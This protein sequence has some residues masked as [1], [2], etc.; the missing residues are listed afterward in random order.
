[1]AL[2]CTPA[3]T[4]HLI[5]WYPT[6][7]CFTWKGLL[8]HNVLK[9]D[10]DC[11]VKYIRFQLCAYYDTSTSA[12]LQFTCL[13]LKKPV[14]GSFMLA[15]TAAYAMFQFG[16]CI[17]TFLWQM[18]WRLD[19]CALTHIAD[20]IYM[21]YMADM[22]WVGIGLSLVLRL[23]LFGLV[24]KYRLHTHAWNEA[25]RVRSV[26]CSAKKCQMI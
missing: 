12:V 22:V 10:A 25:L 11:Q 9:L 2:K 6:F 4:S 26:I 20:G 18:R 19:E 16:I 7:H 13:F 15:I 21:L 3:V 23:W 1:M 8:A 17:S 14:M 5:K 24:T